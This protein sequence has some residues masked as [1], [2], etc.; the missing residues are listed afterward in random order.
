M[1][2]ELWYTRSLR[3]LTST[4]QQSWPGSTRNAQQR[5]HHFLVDAAQTIGWCCAHYQIA[6]LAAYRDVATVFIWMEM[7]VQFYNCSTLIQSNSA[8]YCETILQDDRRIMP[9]C[10][11][12]ASGFGG[13][14]EFLHRWLIG[15]VTCHMPVSLSQVGDSASNL[16]FSQ[17]VVACCCY[18]TLLSNQQRWIMMCI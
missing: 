14:C 8:A 5:H 2:S 13:W 9:R 4:G 1:W 17:I 12:R 6:V 15:K 18:F 11:W 3:I 7:Y 16:W 10:L